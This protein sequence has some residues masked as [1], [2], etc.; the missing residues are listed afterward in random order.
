MKQKDKFGKRQSH[1]EF[2]DSEKTQGVSGTLCRDF[3]YFKQTVAIPRALQLHISTVTQP[4]CGM[5]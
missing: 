1:T 5:K 2:L 4:S 3:Y